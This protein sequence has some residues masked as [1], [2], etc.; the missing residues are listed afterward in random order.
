[1]KFNLQVFSRIA[2]TLFA[3]LFSFNIYAQGIVVNGKVTSA[4]EG[5]PGV[6]VVVK[7]TTSGTV[8][9][10]DGKFRLQVPS[11]DSELVISAIGYVTQTVA[12]NGRSSIDI[13]IKEDVEVL[14][15]VVVIGYA[16]QKKKEVTGAVARVSSETLTQ[17]PTADLGAALQG[18]I[19]GV[20][21]QASSG[22][23]GSDSNIQIRG[24]SSVTGNSAPL[25]VVDGVPYDGDPKVS[26]N[27]IE[28]ID[29]LKDAASASVYG[30]RGSGGV[31]L[32]TTKSG[33]QGQMKVSLDSYY[34]F[35]KIT[36]DLPLMGLED[37]LYANF[38][39]RSHLSDSPLDNTWT[40]L[41]TNPSNFTNN[42]DLTPVLQNDYAIMQNHSLRVSGGKDG[43]TYSIIGTY[44]QQEGTLINSGYDRFNVRANTSY[45][46]KKWTI[47]TGLG[48]RIEEKQHVPWQ[49]LLEAFKY[50]PFQPELD[51]NQSTVEDSGGAGSNEAL[52]LG[53]L[54]TKMKQT[55]VRDGN[56]FNYNVRA[57]YDIA[58]GFKFATRFGGSMTD[59]TRV[60]INPM[61]R[62]Y[63]IEGDPVQLQN[64][65]SIWNQS[66]SQRN[67][68]WENTLNYQKKFKGHQIK[69]L[70][71]FSMEE[72]AFTSF[73]AQ[74]YDLISNE[75][76]VLN[77]ATLD[78]DAGSDK[79][80]NQDKTN[81]LI[82]M[83]GR[84]Q[85]DYKG[86]YLLSVS[87]RRDGSSRF[88][89][90]S[91]WGVFP[92]VS[93]GWNVSEESFF[94]DM[95]SVWNSFKVR[96][97]YGTT[98]NQNF[99]DYSNAATI[100]LTKDY[101]YGGAGSDMLVLGATQTKFANPNVKWETTRQAN[102][103]IDM[104]FFNNKLTFSA[105]FYDTQKEDMLFPVLL[106]PS[107][108]AGKNATVVLNVGNMENKG[109]E[110]ALNY[111]HKSNNGL[112]WSVGGTFSQNRNKITKM[113]GS[114]EVAYLDR[115]TVTDGVPNEDKVSVLREGYEAGA[116]F[117]IETAGVID[118]EQQLEEFRLENQLRENGELLFNEAGEPIIAPFAANTRVGD[119]RYVDQNGDGEITLDDRV[120]RGSGQPDYE[121][122]LNLSADYKGFD[123]SMQI[124]AAIG[125]EV[126]NGSKAYSYKHGTHQDLLYQW[127]DANPTSEI[128]AN[129]GRDYAN[130]RGHTDYWLEDGSFVRLR[131]I[132]LGYTIP[133]AVSESIGVNR[134]RVYVGAQNPL[135]FTNYSGFDPEVGNDG[136]NTRGIDKGNYPISASYRVGVQLDF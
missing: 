129:R 61:F 36:S 13:S 3:L 100:T 16:T 83:L 26:P 97:S 98:G 32:I 22:D 28:S 52:N 81:R 18:Q 99:L 109:M 4:A 17:T 30:T 39:S 7:G 104:A 42:T 63:D 133:K 74:K 64:R 110:F 24:L 5:I 68:A 91:R 134:L 94:E 46:K 71:L 35:Q 37:Y 135:T 95:K 114:T 45:K 87:A 47:T 73:F 75:I 108:G 112:S 53:N 115:S 77:A 33:K 96:G 122:G 107:T 101:V 118:N 125:G 120:Y 11:K 59:N 124:Y 131:N 9:D 105:D 88:A 51:P 12:I 89:E 130:Y 123:L 10:L 119:L 48:F 27:E 58:K 65:S 31:I 128:P 67:W 8:T 14:D 116:F 70:A 66:Q 6:N 78:P 62:I 23:P 113:A 20:N 19:A 1:M 84:V 54:M 85:Y 50:K 111:R 38:L 21:V 121:V 126:L 86:R 127:S 80:W 82:G 55:D 103:G 49:F 57:Q 43:L 79:G 76:P 15:D 56:H 106:P 44:F 102:L 93:A 92:S 34:G 132:A 90:G 2:A 69:A 136:L 40:Q 117:L 41:E 25:Y 60:R 29:I 72:Y